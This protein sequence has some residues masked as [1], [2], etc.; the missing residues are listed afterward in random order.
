[1]KILPSAR[2]IVVIACSLVFTAHLLQTEVSA[3]QQKEAA[4]THRLRVKIDTQ[5]INSV[6]GAE[7][8]KQIGKR[9]SISGKLTP[10]RTPRFGIQDE[11]TKMVIA[12]KSLP[13]P[14]N[15]ELILRYAVKRDRKNPDAISISVETIGGGAKSDE[16]SEIREQR[17]HKLLIPIKEGDVITATGTLC[18]LKVISTGDYELFP[19]IPESHFF[20]SVDNLDVK[21]SQE[22]Q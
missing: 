7:L 10:R 5:D 6:H 18:H 11:K 9:V 3:K 1:M 4:S 19:Q 14:Q 12:F 8:R 15:S 13:V 16:H 20:F 22:K 21:P 17:L 2:L